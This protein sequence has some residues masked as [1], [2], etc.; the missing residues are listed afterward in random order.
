MPIQHPDMPPIIR[1]RAKASGSNNDEHFESAL[2]DVRIAHP[3]TELPQ[4]EEAVL[5]EEFAEEALPELDEPFEREYSQRERLAAIEAMLFA[6]PVPVK[7]SELA[8]ASGWKASVIEGDLDALDDYLEPRGFQLQRVVGAYRL[9]TKSSQSRF[10]ERLLGVQ[11]RRR[12]TRAQL[13]TLA[14]V[15]YRQP[16]TRAQA[17]ALRGVSC[18]RLLGQLVDLRLIREVGRAELPG[19]PILYGTTPEFLKYFNLNHVSDL[20]DIG[21]LKR[22]I[23]PAEVS[24]SQASWNAAARGE[25]D[26]PEGFESINVAPPEAAPPAAVAP[27]SVMQAI[28]AEIRAIPVETGPS[29]GLMKLFNKIRGKKNLPTRTTAE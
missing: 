24:A 28:G 13:E 8:E 14:I 5:D 22:K 7:L 19:R 25:T 11:T 21:E 18:E 27:G 15:G 26:R 4:Q 29:Q 9:V 23:V 17:E 10:V 12:L 3:Q 2:P 1:S 16:V 6:S 20:P